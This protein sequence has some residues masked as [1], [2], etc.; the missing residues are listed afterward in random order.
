MPK[1]NAEMET[2]SKEECN[3][4]KEI[5]N[6]VKESVK[7]LNENQMGCC[8]Y[9]LD[10][11]LAVCVGWADTGYSE[12]AISAGIKVLTS[13][14]MLTDYDWINF[15]YY[16]NGEVLDM[17]YTLAYPGDIADGKAEWI[18]YEDVAE[19]LLRWYDEVKYLEMDNT[20]LI[21]EE[22]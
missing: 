17:G 3:M 16:K 20:G 22:M 6:F 19:D 5:A 13:A 21:K 4:K 14:Y 8:H 9:K 7:W 12:Y 10:D 11:H 2:K 15:P 18:H 1:Y